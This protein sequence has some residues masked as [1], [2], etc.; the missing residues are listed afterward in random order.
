MTL[1]DFK[2]ES[3]T[4]E[5]RYENAYAIWDAAGNCAKTISKIWPG[6]TLKKAEPGEIAFE[7][8]GVRV[9]TGI[10]TSHI[11]F[12]Q[13]KS[14]DQ[15][16]EAISQTF[17]QWNHIL[18][19]KEYTRLGCRAIYEK[20][21]D[22]TESANEAMLSL[23]LVKLPTKKLFNV[24]TTDNRNTFDVRYLLSD[25]K[26]G[27]TIRVFPNSTTVEIN[28]QGAMPDL[29]R[30]HTKHTLTIDIDRYTKQAI[31]AEAFKVSEW[32]KGTAHLIRRDLPQLLGFTQ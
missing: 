19:I 26:S 5:A 29:D 8:S 3:M 23:G 11:L 18:D 4:I 14:F 13:P 31:A 1:D 21:Y 27:T 25:Q 32:L 17:H 30:K 6:T 2:L 12:R 28:T 15:H 10:A 16:A 7:S 22:S 20:T 9:L 24:E